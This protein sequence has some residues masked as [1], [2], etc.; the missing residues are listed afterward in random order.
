MILTCSEPSHPAPSGLEHQVTSQTLRVAARHT[1][2][3]T[4]WL[5]HVQRRRNANIAAVALANKHAR[6]VWA[7]LAHDRDYTP[8]YAGTS[9]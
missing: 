9:P 5:T 4:T 3:T 6:I 2:P 8:D 7:L 1:D